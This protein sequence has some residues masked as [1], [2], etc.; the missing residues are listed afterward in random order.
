MSSLSRMLSAKFGLASCCLVQLVVPALASDLVGEANNLLI[1]LLIALGL[2]IIYLYR[3]RVITL[4]TGDDR[5][6]FDVH[7]TIWQILTCCRLCECECT[8]AL[9]SSPCW[10]FPGSKGRNLLRLLGQNLG[11]VQIPIELT[12]IIV[13]DLPAMSSGD[14]YLTVETSSNPPQ[15]TAVVENADPK[16]VAFP[17]SL[18]IKVRNSTLESNVR[19][20]VKKMHAVGSVEI[21]DCYISPKML[22]LWEEN[23]QGPVRIRMEPC[24]R[25]YNFTLPAWILMELREHV[26]PS[27]GVNQFDITVRN[28]RTGDAIPYET[29]QDFKKD[30]SLVDVSGF[31]SQ[32]PDETSVGNIDAAHRAKAVCLG[33]LFM[34]LLLGSGCFLSSRLYCKACFQRY[35]EITVL[36]NFGVLFPV[37]SHD[38]TFYSER[39]ALD[40]N[41]FVGLVEDDVLNGMHKL[42]NEKVDPNCTVTREE[43]MRLGSPAWIFVTFR[44]L[45]KFRSF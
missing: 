41:I 5:V 33:Q 27:R 29:P 16:V 25:D 3:D 32:E 22:L 13:G 9:T 7:S 12:N 39:C 2:Y 6:H 36:N 42:S 30:Y 1:L 8:R 4:L 21:C 40:T 17:D 45:H 34:I 18:I 20:C 31:Q 26:Q 19:F 23:E 28:I 10:P 11:V 14:Y 44:Q 35:S 43:V 38:R 37:F 15:I 24:R